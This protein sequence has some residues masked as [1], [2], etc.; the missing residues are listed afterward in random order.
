MKNNVAYVFLVIGAVL[1]LV[2]SGVCL[3]RS[4]LKVISQT[5]IDYNAVVLN[6]N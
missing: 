2:G 6:A 4:I 1:L 5:T 3:T